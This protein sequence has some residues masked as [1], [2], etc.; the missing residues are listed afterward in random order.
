MQSYQ[1][2]IFGFSWQEKTIKSLDISYPSLKGKWKPIFNRVYDSYVARV[3]A[4]AKPYAGINDTKTINDLQAATGDDPQNIGRVLSAIAAIDREKITQK[5]IGVLTK[6]VNAPAEAA[7]AGARTLLDK[8][9]PYLIPLGVV[10]VGGAYLYFYK[11]KKDV[12][13]ALTVKK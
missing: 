12:L 13:E 6:L 5:H 10:A 1:L 9:A 7:A 8:M 2:G 4:G 3:A 11:S